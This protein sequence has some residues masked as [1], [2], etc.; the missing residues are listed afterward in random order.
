MYL[1]LL[2]P[3]SNVCTWRTLNVSPSSVQGGESE[4]ELEQRQQE[5]KSREGGTGLPLGKDP[6]NTGA[7]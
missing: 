3:S 1:L 6:S 5:P 4:A 2:R 7:R